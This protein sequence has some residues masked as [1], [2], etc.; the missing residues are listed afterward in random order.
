MIFQGR[1]TVVVA[2]ATALPF[3]SDAFLQPSVVSSKES[4]TLLWLQE[5]SNACPE[6]QIN[7]RE[8]MKQSLGLVLGATALSTSPF[9]SYA[10][11][12]PS[13]GN[14]PDLP[15]EAVRSYLQYR[16]PLQTSADFYLFDI[17]DTLDDPSNWGSIG[18]LFQ[19]KP[20]RIEREF[21]NVMRV[22]GLSMPPDEAEEMR[23]AQYEFEKAMA[24]LSKITLGIRRDL[25][26]E[27]DPQIVSK[28]KAA[29]DDG[30]VGLNKLY[31]Q[32]RS[33]GFLKSEDSHIVNFAP[34]PFQS[35]H[36]ERNYGTER[37]ENHSTDRPQ[38][39]R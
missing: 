17:L 6:P 37:N 34:R 35:N 30:R 20:T 15:G 3:F 39:A 1:R 4:S 19:S 27:L 16:A 23:A 18:E 29:W 22:V 24:N 26:V 7:R 36:P 8:V 12:G 21:T 32:M 31:V 14:L 11:T 5:E 33:V 28:A 2:L 13:D 25:P 10:A 38:P 9:P